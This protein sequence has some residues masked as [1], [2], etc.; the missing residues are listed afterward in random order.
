MIDHKLALEVLQ[1]QGA[2]YCPIHPGTK[3]PAGRE[4]QRNPHTLEQITTPSLGLMLG[5]VSAG[6]FAIDF[7]GD[8]AFDYYVNNISS[9]LATTVMWSSGRPGRFQAAYRMPEL[10]RSIMPTKFAVTTAPGEQIEWRYGNSD[11]GFQS[12]MPPSRHPDLGTEYF[13]LKGFSPLDVEVAECPTELLEWAVKT[14]IKPEPVPYSATG[15]VNLPIDS[16]AALKKI[17]EIIVTM[18]PG[19]R[20]VKAC[21]VGG[22]MRHV[23]QR[24]WGTVENMLREKG[25][26]RAAIASARKYAVS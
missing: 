10:L 14:A 3:R 21:K 13:W 17:A 18:G 12:V 26:D 23:D 8:S 11:R 20:S 1:A 25:C 24:M 7:D 22:L 15:T 6:I 2:R 5:E 4:W 16:N 9:D 19:D